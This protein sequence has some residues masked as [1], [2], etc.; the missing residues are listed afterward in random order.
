MNMVAIRLNAGDVVELQIDNELVSALV[1]LASDDAVIL[2][3]CDGSTPF[4]MRPDD[5][6]GARVYAGAT[7]E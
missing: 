5:L 3:A 1:M 4:V 7:A 2:D 6:L